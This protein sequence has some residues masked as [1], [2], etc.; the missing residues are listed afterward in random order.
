M[1]W[2]SNTFLLQFHIMPLYNNISPICCCCRLINV[3]LLTDNWRSQISWDHL[4]RTDS[5]SLWSAMT[6]DGF[7][8]RT[9]QITNIRPESTTPKGQPIKVNLIA[10]VMEFYV[11]PQSG[12]IYLQQQQVDRRKCNPFHPSAQMRSKQTMIAEIYVWIHCK[13]LNQIIIIPL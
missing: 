1:L 5:S 4:M 11:T 10:S 7:I 8:V 6:A 2:Q 13:L 12:R 3:T 9:K